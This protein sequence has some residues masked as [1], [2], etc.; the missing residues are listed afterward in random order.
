MGQNTN[1]FIFIIESF[2]DSTNKD[3]FRTFVVKD[4]LSVEIIIMQMFA[5]I[6]KLKKDYY[7]DSNNTTNF[8]N[9]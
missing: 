6:D 4:G 7:E 1:K 5:F 9:H 2:D 3:K 8:I